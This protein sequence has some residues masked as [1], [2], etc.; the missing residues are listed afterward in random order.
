MGSYNIKCCVT[1]LPIRWGDEIVAIP[2]KKYENTF[3]FCFEYNKGWAVCGYPIFGTYVDCG[4]FEPKYKSDVTFH[5]FMGRWDNLSCTE[6]DDAKYSFFVMHR[7]VYLKIIDWYETRSNVFS[8]ELVSM[9]YD[10]HDS[11]R[12]E[13]FENL[14][15]PYD[16]DFFMKMTCAYEMNKGYSNHP[17]I[18]PFYYFTIEGS[19]EVSYIRY[20]LAIHSTVFPIIEA[21]ASLGYDICPANYAEQ[22]SNFKEVLKWKTELVKDVVPKSEDDDDDDDDE[23]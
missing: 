19:D 11:K 9:V 4:R 21:A 12:D 20:E 1:R 18:N 2:I 16:I 5:S 3:G 22:V 8:D 7:D 15:P 23:Y 6:D 17:I 13:V 14:K 10:R